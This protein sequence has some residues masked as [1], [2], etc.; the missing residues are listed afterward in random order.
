MKKK[1]PKLKRKKK[2][3]NTLFKNSKGKKFKN[4][5]KNKKIQ[6]KSSVEMKNK[7]K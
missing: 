1:L 5:N 3:W 6:F 4:K 2:K 7:K